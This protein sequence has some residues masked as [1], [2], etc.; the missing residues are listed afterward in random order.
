[1]K[2]SDTQG[3]IVC[4]EPL[5]KTKIVLM[6]VVM[7]FL[8]FALAG[9]ERTSEPLALRTLSARE[10]YPLAVDYAQNWKSDA[11]LKHISVTFVVKE[12][13]RHVLL[14]YDFESPSDDRHS[15]QVTFQEGS[16]E[17]E[18]ETIDHSIPIQVYNPISREAWSLDSVDILSIAQKNGGDKFLMRYEPEST[19]TSLELEHQAPLVPGSRLVWRASYLDMMTRDT[20]DITINPDTG[21]IIEIG[22][23]LH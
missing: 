4:R 13:S 2:P 7:W 22:E 23:D 12:S 8:L 20:L 5:T 11:H 10:F 19:L 18:V 6:L 17:P 9:C 21:E 1:M 15:L 14:F 3:R 16:T